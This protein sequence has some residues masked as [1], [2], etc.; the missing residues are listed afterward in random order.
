M[1][2]TPFEFDRI[3]TEPV[4]HL[5][6]LRGMIWAAKTDGAGHLD[7]STSA[8]VSDTMTFM[9]TLTSI[10]LEI[11]GNTVYWI[12]SGTENAYIYSLYYNPETDNVI[13]EQVAEFR[14]GFICTCCFGYLNTVYVGGYYL[15][16]STTRSQ[17]V[18]YAYTQGNSFLLTTIGKDPDYFT[19]TPDEFVNH[20]VVSLFAGN[21]K[22][23]IQTPNSVY[24]WDI[25]NG[26]YHHITDVFDSDTSSIIGG[27]DSDAFSGI[28]F[29]YT[30]YQCENQY[31]EAFIVPKLAYYKGK[32][33]GP[34]L[35]DT[36]AKSISVQSAT[37]ASPTVVTTGTGTGEMLSPTHPTGTSWPVEYVRSPVEGSGW[38]AV[39][40]KFH[41]VGGGN[42]VFEYTTTV[43]PNTSY[44]FVM[45]NQCTS[46]TSGLFFA[47][48]YFRNSLGGL[49]SMTDIRAFS[50]G[51]DA[52]PVTS[53]VTVT[54]PSTAT[55]VTISAAMLITS[56]CVMTWD[57]TSFSMVAHGS[58]V[59]DT[60]LE[61]GDIVYL[62]INSTP[63]ILGYYKVEV[64]TPSTF[65]VLSLVDGSHVGIAT[66]A[67]TSGTVS[68]NKSRGLAIEGEHYAGHGVIQSSTSNF[69]TGTMA[70]DF[71]RIEVMHDPL[72]TGDIL[73]ASYSLNGG[74]FQVA[75][76]ESTSTNKTTFGIH[77]TGYSI[78]IK[79]D[80]VPASEDTTPVV[81]SWNVIWD[82]L[83]VDRHIYTLDCRKGAQ[84]GRWSGDATAAI[85]HLMDAAD[86]EATF[87]DRFV[88]Y[89]G[90]I[91][92]IEYQQAGYSQKEGPSGIVTLQVRQLEGTAVASTGGGTT[93]SESALATRITA[94]EAITGIVPASAHYTTFETDG[95]M[96]MN[97]NATVWEDLRIEP[98]ARTTGSFAPTFEKY[99]DDSGGTSRGVYLYSFDDAA[100]NAEKE[101][102]FSMQMPH[103]WAA[104]PISLHVHWVGTH[105]DTVAAPRWGLEY[106]WRSIG[107]TFTDSVII[108]TVDKY[109]VD[110]NV[111]ALKHYLSE[112]VD[113][114]PSTTAN[115][116]SSILV[117][118]LFRNSSD[119]A[120]TYNV[121]GNKC[122]L[123]YIDAHYEA[124]TLGSREELTK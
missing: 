50:S 19:E 14:S 38:T 33:C 29:D 73:S 45:V 42:E 44:D 107:G 119:A 61:T 22:L 5:S 113:L 62:D 72:L 98:T 49:V 124:N 30:A 102:F 20:R 39:G 26:G 31:Y 105:N 64:Q 18:V 116:I 2:H 78:A 56:G 4:Y 51:T 79:V 91:E 54:S 103:S 58:A 117:G 17:G 92:K 114:N 83:K 34:Y 74:D 90:I 86:E 65:H 63:A 40:D 87:E 88:S 60:D 97:G 8:Y 52:S 108:Y 110:A 12:V 121:S 1:T 82:F 7:P 123:L 104:T 99:V 109:P 35:I 85:Q 96:V 23:Y 3:N 69:H 53:S 68:Y 94:L 106:A 112:F 10:G 24:S 80:I 9:S 89:Q 47:R 48:V 77:Q 11:A 41:G 16:S 101:V 120:D 67:G 115:G 71:R 100:S 25:V 55:T 111:T 43:N 95:T 36:E 93:A 70:K 27:S 66:T 75:T 81:R 6:Y 21:D 37:K 32:V 46:Y 118:R 57:I 15:N 13:C 59:I 28:V 84:G 76:Q 122:G